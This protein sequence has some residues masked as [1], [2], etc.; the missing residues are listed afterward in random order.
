MGEKPSLARAVLHQNLSAE[1]ASIWPRRVRFLGNVS[2]YKLCDFVS[3][4]QLI[5]YADLS[6]VFFVGSVSKFVVMRTIATH[7]YMRRCC[8]FLLS[9]SWSVGFGSSLGEDSKCFGEVCSRLESARNDFGCWFV[10]K[11]ESRRRCCRK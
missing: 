5:I 11:L 6:S 4:I 9:P 7:F 10:W 3:C 1:N 8:L 2:I